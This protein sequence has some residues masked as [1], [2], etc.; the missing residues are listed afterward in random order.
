MWY[1]P[2]FLSFTVHPYQKSSSASV[3][4]TDFPSMPRMSLMITFP[5]LG[6]NF[7]VSVC[8]AWACNAWPFFKGSQFSASALHRSSS[9]RFNTVVVRPGGNWMASSLS[10]APWAVT[11]GERTAVKL[12]KTEARIRTRPLLLLLC[13]PARPLFTAH[14][15][16]FSFHL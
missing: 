3:G 2:A 13:T 4:M 11:D 5:P 15:L 16:H 12:K 10:L 9:V 8:P 14:A 1:S 6:L 7:S